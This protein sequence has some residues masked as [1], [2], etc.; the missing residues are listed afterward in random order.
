MRY[1]IPT[2]R[3]IRSVKGCYSRYF[4][5]IL[6]L[7]H[8]AVLI[9]PPVMFTMWSMQ[10]S[11]SASSPISPSAAPADWRALPKILLHEHLDG[12][13]RPATLLELCRQQNVAVPADTADGLAAWLL[14]NSNSGS[15]VRYLTGFGLTVAAM[16]SV[17]ACERVAFEAAEDARTDG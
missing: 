9:T 5:A 17:E 1:C 15:L 3:R 6:C 12:G 16:G 4:Y 10:T 13:L 2:K 11:T 7:C 8:C 14:A